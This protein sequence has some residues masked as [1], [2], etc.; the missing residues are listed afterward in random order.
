MS[1][2][3]WIPRF[4]PA[5]T[6]ALTAACAH[7]AEQPCP[8]TANA[9]ASQTERTELASLGWLDPAS[10][11]E[12][13]TPLALFDVRWLILTGDSGAF[14]SV[15][16]T[17]HNFTLGRWE[18]ALSAEKPSD[19]LEDGKVSVDRKRRVVCTHA[20]GVIAQSELQCAW[21]TPSPVKN[22]SPAQG[23][24]ELRLSLSDAPGVSI[25]CEPESKERLPVYTGERERSAEACIVN[26]R[27][28]SCPSA[29]P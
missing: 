25:S 28:L 23:K 14:A 19:R 27:V 15:P 13:Q 21:Q 3:P 10:L 5:L 20:T 8:A 11:A 4:A 6:V 7:S 29:T 18:C 24:R 22:G 2:V 1:C 9:P 12:A 26:G 17:L 16:K